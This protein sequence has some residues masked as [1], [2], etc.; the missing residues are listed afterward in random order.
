MNGKKT[1]CADTS[2][3]ITFISKNE[4]FTMTLLQ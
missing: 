2:G 1:Q 4:T 3:N